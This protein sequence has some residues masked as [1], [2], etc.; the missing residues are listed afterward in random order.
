MKKANDGLGQMHFI[1]LHTAIEFDKGM[2]FIPELS[3]LK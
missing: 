2:K 1:S 3:N